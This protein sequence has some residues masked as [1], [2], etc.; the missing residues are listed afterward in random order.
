MDK[1]MCKVI[2]QLSEWGF[3]TS[4]F[5]IKGEAYGVGF[6]KHTGLR[7]GGIECWILSSHTEQSQIEVCHSI[8]DVGDRVCLRFD[9]Q[10]YC[11]NFWLADLIFNKY[12]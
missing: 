9:R 10:G 4:E 2:K 11:V 1:V 6:M 8:T 5:D 3:D 7:Y 12:G